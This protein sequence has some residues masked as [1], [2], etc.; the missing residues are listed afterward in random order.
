[1]T[2]VARSRVGWCVAIAVAMLAGARADAQ[3]SVPPPRA[4]LDS[5]AAAA[6][7]NVRMQCRPYGL[8]EFEDQGLLEGC[9]GHS[10]DT[11][12]VRYRTR[13]GGPLAVTR[14]VYVP[15]GRLTTVADSVREQ[16]S[17]EYGTAHACPETIWSGPDLHVYQWHFPGLTVQLAVNARQ[18]DSGGRVYP[19]VAVQWAA[20]DLPCDDWIRPPLHR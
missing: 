15:R 7:R 2:P 13:R 12:V 17:M 4:S 18:D 10:F 5:I 16:L 19:Q 8:T 6:S 11:V 1:M 20:A 9:I 3:T 14:Q